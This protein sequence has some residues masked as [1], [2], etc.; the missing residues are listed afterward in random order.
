MNKNYLIDRRTCLK[1]EQACGRLLSAI[2]LE[3]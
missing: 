1:G 2:S 3:S